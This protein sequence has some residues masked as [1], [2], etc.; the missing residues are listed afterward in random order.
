MHRRHGPTFAGFFRY[1]EFAAPLQLGAFQAVDGLAWHPLVIGPPGGYA[2]LCLAFAVMA[3]LAC[4]AVWRGRPTR[5]RLAWAAAW[6]VAW[7]ALAVSARAVYGGET[8]Q[9]LRPW[10]S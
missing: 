8:L 7:A 5:E 9:L 3:G 6:I 10:E 4:R 2:L 1:V